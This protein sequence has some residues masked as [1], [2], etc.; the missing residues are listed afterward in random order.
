MTKIPGFKFKREKYKQEMYTMTLDRK[1]LEYL[2]MN[3]AGNSI[4]FF[5]FPDGDT[6]TILLKDNKVS[7]DVSGGVQASSV[8]DEE[9]INPPILHK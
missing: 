9:E 5:I 3:M 8:N 4:S 6:T 7:A 1:F 2:M